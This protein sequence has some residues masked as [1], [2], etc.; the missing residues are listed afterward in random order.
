MKASGKRGA[1]TGKGKNDKKAKQ[2]SGKGP[3]RQEEM[4]ELF[5]NDMSEWKQGRSLKKNNV[6]RK[7]SKNSFKSKSRYVTMLSPALVFNRKIHLSIFFIIQNYCLIHFITT[8]ANT[9]VPKISK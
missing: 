3:T 9:R 4:Q 1:G 5:Q 7:K 8:D 6:M 2:H